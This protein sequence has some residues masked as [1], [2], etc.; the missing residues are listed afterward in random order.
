MTSRI[1]ANGAL[2]HTAG[3]IVWATPGTGVQWNNPHPS[4]NGKTFQAYYS[5]TIATPNGSAG[6]EYK[7][8]NTASCGDPD[9][10]GYKCV[11]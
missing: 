8:G 11:F 3:P 10:G 6:N 9:G 1:Y 7:T 4:T 5:F 2:S